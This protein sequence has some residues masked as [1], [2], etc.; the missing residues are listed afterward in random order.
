MIIWKKRLKRRSE[1][2]EIAGT[3]KRLE[4]GEE[5]IKKKKIRTR[6]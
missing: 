2:L 4:A 3:K 6:K 5:E 1:K